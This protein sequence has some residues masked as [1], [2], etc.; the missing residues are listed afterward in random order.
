MTADTHT[1]PP[2][3]AAAL[4]AHDAGLSVVRVRNDGTKR[5]VGEWK[6]LQTQRADR[7]TVARWFTGTTHGLGVICGAVSGDLEMLE[8]EGR[9]MDQL[10]STAFRKAMDDAG[11]A[12][13]LRR[14]VNGFMVVSPSGGRHFYY[15]VDGEAGPN[16]KLA[17]R[18]ATDY[19][20]FIHHTKIILP[21][22]HF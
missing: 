17:R 7:D 9:F 2:I 11:L 5:P 3:L 12:L 20:I 21:W 10:G 6:A 4:D 19:Q 16:T 13:L 15:R 22:N 14:L 1:I 8:L 18:P